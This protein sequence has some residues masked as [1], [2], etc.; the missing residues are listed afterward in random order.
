MA[1]NPGLVRRVETVPVVTLEQVAMK[2]FSGDI[3]G[4]G[5]VSV[6]RTQTQG[7]PIQVHIT[8]S[9]TEG[10]ISSRRIAIIVGTQ[11]GERGFRSATVDTENV[12]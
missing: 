5:H 6:N 3:A 1:F 10:Q 9:F 7:E 11:E 4:A 12:L 2:G 8:Q